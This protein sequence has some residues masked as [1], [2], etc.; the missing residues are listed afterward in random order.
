MNEYWK[1][2]AEQRFKAAEKDIQEYYKGLIKAFEQ[3]KREINAVIYEFYL[4]YAENNKISLAEAQNYL[5][6]NELKEFKGNLEEFIKMAKESIGKVNPEIE[7]LSIK[8]RITRYQALEAQINE[9]LEKL[10]A[11][12]Y[13]Q[14]GGQKLKDIYED[15]YYK[16]LFDIGQYRGF[17]YEF[18]LLN[19][20]VIDEL[21][22]YPFNGLNFSDRIWRQKGDLIYKLRE[23]MTTAFIQGKNPKELAESFA[24]VFEV[25]QHE[26]YRLL[27]T[28]TAFMAEQATLQAYKDDGIEQYEFSA[29][30]DLRT[31]DICREHDGK[32]YDVD[33]AIVGLNYPPMHPHCRS[34]TVPYFGEKEG[35]RVARGTDGKT[36]PVP[37][38]MTYEQWYKEYIVD[39]Y[40]KEQAEIMRNKIKN[41][42]ADKKQFE[43]YKEVLGKDAPKSFEKF[44]ELKYNDIEKWNKIKGDYQKLNAY[45]KIVAHEPK[46]TADLQDI[47]KSTGVEM[48]GLEYRLKSKESY[49]RKINSDSKNSLDSKIINDTIANTN[50]VIRY[51]YQAGGDKLVDAFTAVTREMEAKGYLRYKIKNT[52]SDKRNPYKG[53]NGIFVSPQGQKFEVQFHTPESFEL[54]NGKLHKLYEEYRLD[55][56]IPERKSELVKEMFALSSKLTKPKDIEKIK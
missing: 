21:I 18:A 49:M 30:L 10:Y 29:T 42:T 33:K 46:I 22:K 12:D 36:Y 11:I 34:T 55:S 54:K 15:Q 17:N 38:S 53:I 26:A 2:R 8:A 23:A 52:W 48:V 24:K 20:D 13:E 28:E 5:N 43:R 50:D 6:F 41:E 45:K 19:T 37:A 39:K 9:I 3:A 25:K 44:Q 32:V 4:K 56:T 35:T 7:N 27:H 47:S 31:S 51:T 16:T 40:G 1:K 14:Y